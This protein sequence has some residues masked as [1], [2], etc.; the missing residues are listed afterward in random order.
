MDR[1]YCPHCGAE[2]PPRARACPECGSDEA[3]GWSE[4]A[5]EER[6]GVPDEEFD[7]EEFVREE[8][9]GPKRARHNLKWFW[10]GAAV[11]LLLILIGSWVF[12]LL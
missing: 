5:H 2:L 7:Y 8:F 3:T 11:L 12:H 6:L 1:D 10:W 9:G 4:R